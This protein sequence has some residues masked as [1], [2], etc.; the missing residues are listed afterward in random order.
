[1]DLLTEL[2][3]RGNFSEIKWKSDYVNYL[4]SAL[5]NFKKEEN[6]GV[7]GNDIFHFT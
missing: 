6:E 7:R 1:M 2:K 4:S 3:Y 5:E